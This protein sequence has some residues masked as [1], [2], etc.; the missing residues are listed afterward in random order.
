MFELTALKPL[1]GILA[2]VF[3]VCS[4]LPYLRDIFARKTQPH[5]YSWLIWSILQTT[6]V[7]AMII[8]GAGLGAWTLGIGAF[9][10]VFIF[11]ASFKYGTKNITVFDTIC[12]MGALAAVVLWIIQKDPLYSVV[13]IT[14]I[15]FI[16]FLP[17]YR[18][19]FAEPYTET[20]LAYV[21]WTIAY[22]L[23]TLAIMTYSIT[24]TLYIASLV[25]T[26][27]IC[28]A[29]LLAGRQRQKKIAAVKA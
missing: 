6:A 21:L 8:G 11:L 20:V 25:V 5:I 9:F 24:T 4:F 19:G 15:D 27:A 18:K 29:V 26:D 10:A 22:F 12:L 1:F 23:G 3:E 28:V 2:M 17:T 13:L 14:A 16:G 7:A